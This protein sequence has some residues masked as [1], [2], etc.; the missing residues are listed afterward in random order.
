MNAIY[1]SCYQDSTTFEY[2]FKAQIEHVALSVSPYEI[3]MNSTLID[4]SK[5]TEL[6]DKS[7]VSYEVLAGINQ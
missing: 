6:K 3:R 4:G 5:S 7:H 2:V 1:A